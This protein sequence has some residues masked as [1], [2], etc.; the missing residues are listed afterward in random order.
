MLRI[1]IPAAAAPPVTSA[2][3]AGGSGMAVSM[4]AEAMRRPMP[5]CEV[6][7]PYPTVVAVVTAQYRPVV[8]GRSWD[9]REQLGADQ[10]A[11]QAGG[12][13]AAMCSRFRW[14]S[15][16]TRRSITPQVVP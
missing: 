11:G 6:T 12:Q 15:N 5:L 4:T 2:K 16:L 9:Q 13:S 10:H 1:R 3:T 7:S 14:F 8:S